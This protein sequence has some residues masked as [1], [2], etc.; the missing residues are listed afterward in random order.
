VSEDVENFDNPLPVRSPSGETV[1]VSAMSRPIL[2]AP[3][4][5]DETLFASF[6]CLRH[7]PVVV[8][9]YRSKVQEANGITADERQAE[10]SCAVAHLGVPAWHQWP[11]HDSE[12]NADGIEGNMWG[13]LDPMSDDK[14]L[15]FAPA[16]HAKGHPQHNL[17]ADLADMVFGKEH[18]IHYTTYL[19]GGPRHVAK[20]VIF[21]P[22]WIAPKLSALACY[23]SQ[24]ERGP[25]RMW[26]DFGLR[27]YVT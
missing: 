11:W 7:R 17:V 25:N 23:R 15:V 24:T 13:M 21:D 9:C 10:T 18:V 26:L 16:W 8:V 14:P 6:L 27:E 3:H 12:L 20:E 2:F 1:T 4:N 5:D 19:L 22:A